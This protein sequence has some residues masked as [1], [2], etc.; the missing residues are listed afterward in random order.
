[1]NRLLWLLGLLVLVGA[2]V[3]GLL[4]AGNQTR[5]DT[6]LILADVATPGCDAPGQVHL[7]LGNAGDRPIGKVEGV[8]SVAATDAEPPVPVGNFDVAGPVG[9]GQR[10]EA[11]VPV[12]ESQLAGKDRVTL[13][14]LARATV[15]EFEDAGSR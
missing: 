10:L 13:T 8:L 2:G 12:D 4:S 5:L 7:V 11:C 9:P 14:W 15:I 6:A 3:L 1:M